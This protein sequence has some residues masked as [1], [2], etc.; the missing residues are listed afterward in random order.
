MSINNG[1]ST[2]DN[3]IVK[4]NTSNLL[5][6]AGDCIV[7]VTGLNGL[8]LTKEKLA[9]G[10]LKDIYTITIANT[11]GYYIEVTTI[12]GQLL[13]TYYVVKAE[14]LNAVSIIIIVVSVVLVVAGSVVF[15][16][17]SRKMKIR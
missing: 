9:A 6:S 15:V 14:P 12:S 16:M 1:E 8:V 10:D 17:M 13:Y 5:D 11:G 3:I 4:F 7:K 2:T